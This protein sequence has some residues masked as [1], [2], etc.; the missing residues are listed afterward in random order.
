MLHQQK[1]QAI[2]IARLHWMA[3]G[4]FQHIQICA[5]IENCWRVVLDSACDSFR[6]SL[7]LFEDENPIKSRSAH[8][9]STHLKRLYSLTLLLFPGYAIRKEI[10]SLHPLEDEAYLRKRNEAFLCQF[11]SHFIVTTF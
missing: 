3:R 5:C 11:S 6:L 9:I 10:Y 7:S 8:I 4:R 2:K 1:R